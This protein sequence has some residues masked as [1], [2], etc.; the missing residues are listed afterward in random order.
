[1]TS[2]AQRCYSQNIPLSALAG[3]RLGWGCRPLLNTSN[4]RRNLNGKLIRV[5]VSVNLAFPAAG[6][7]FKVSAN[8]PADG[9]ATASGCP[10]P[11]RTADAT[12]HSAWTPRAPSPTGCAA[13]AA[14]LVR[15]RVSATFDENA[16]TGAFHE[17]LTPEQTLEGRGPRL[18]HDPPALRAVTKRAC[19]NSRAFPEV[20]PP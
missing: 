10:L 19:W 14:G 12:S 18:R 13:T 20:L 9:G 6:V 15:A 7:A 11:T 16:I 4:K 5:Q 3:G 1:M 17:G 2:P 8:D